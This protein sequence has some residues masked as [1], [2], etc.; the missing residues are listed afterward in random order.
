GGSPTSVVLSS[1]NALPAPVV[2]GAGGRVPPSTIIEDDSGPNVETDG[3]I[4]DPAQDGIDFYESLEG[5]RVQ[6]NNALAVGPSKLFGSTS[7]E[8]YVVADGGAG[9]GLRTARGGVVIQAGDFN[10]E[11]LVLANDLRS[12]LPDADVGD[13]F[14][15][16]IV[17]VLSYD[18]GN[19]RLLD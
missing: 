18:F 3:N 7:K 1:G 4:F 17:G 14:A 2:I 10:P 13:S 19:F 11:R 5:M 16:A 12:F 15:G 6:M 8:I 9:A